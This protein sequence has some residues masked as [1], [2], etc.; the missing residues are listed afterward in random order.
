[1][2]INPGLELQAAVEID[3]SDWC[4][5]L[6]DGHIW[7]TKLVGWADSAFVEAWKA[8]K[9]VSEVPLCGVDPA[10][11]YDPGQ[12]D[13]PQ[14]HN[15]AGL[16]YQLSFFNSPL[17]ELGSEEERT[18][19]ICRFA[20]AILSATNY[21][22]MPDSPLS[23]EALARVKEFRQAV[24]D[25]DLLEGFP[26]DGGFSNTP[27]PVLETPTAYSTN[28]LTNKAVR[29][30]LNTMP[31]LKYNQEYDV[32]ELSRYPVFVAKVQLRMLANADKLMRRSGGAPTRV[33]YKPGA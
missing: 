24:R 19:S 5:R 6:D 30:V 7:S 12:P 18:E 4:W 16:A 26:F 17:G 9:S 28:E 22:V 13:A 33:A 23:E 8:R 21:A 32:E 1:M 2:Q 15:E 27:W 25:M 14:P 29:Q 11:Q 20:E 3:W 31:A 10:W